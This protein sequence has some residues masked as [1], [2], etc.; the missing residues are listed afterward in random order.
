MSQSLLIEV[1]FPTYKADYMGWREVSQSLLIEVFFPTHETHFYTQK[2]GESQSL[3]IE[4]F[5]P[6]AE[7]FNLKRLEVAIPSN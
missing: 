5:F 2:W 6:T 1:F 3:L 7:K 4:V